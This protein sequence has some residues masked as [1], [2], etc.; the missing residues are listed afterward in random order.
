MIRHIVLFK[1]KPEFGWDDQ[2]TQLAERK[3]ADVGAR[4]PELKEWRTGRNI[5]AR[6]AAYDFAVMGLLADEDALQRYLDHPFHQESVRLWR[7]ISDWVVAD[8]LERPLGSF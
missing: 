7:T 8:L 1:F 5:S 6:P 2:I 3:A 4:V